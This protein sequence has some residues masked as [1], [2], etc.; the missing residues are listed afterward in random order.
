MLNV[1]QKKGVTFPI[2]DMQD[3]SALEALVSSSIRKSIFK[4]VTLTGG[5]TRAIPFTR[6]SLEIA[7]E[8]KR[9]PVS[10][11]D[12]R[13]LARKPSL[14]EWKE[15]SAV[16]VKVY[17]NKPVT[18]ISDLRSPLEVGMLK[19]TRGRTDL[20]GVSTMYMR[21]APEPFA[22]GQIRLAYHG[23]LNRKHDDLHLEKSEM[24]LKAYKHTGGYVNDLDQY[25][26]Q[27]EISNIVYFLATEYNKS[28]RPR[29][30]ATIQCLQNCVIEETS[31]INE[32]SGDRRFCAEPP[33]PIATGAEFTKYSNNTGYWNDDE[34]DETLLR[35]TLYTYEITGEY[36]MV[37]DL[38]GIRKDGV[39]Y[40]TD[41]VILCNDLLRFGNT[42]L[43]RPFMKKCLE[44]TRA[45][46]AD[47]GWKE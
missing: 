25:L 8:K 37:T 5:A 16:A 4:T 17:R 26:K 13:I 2:V 31:D 14:R 1:F 6:G 15:Q 10:L 7:A 30:C 19:K 42:N 22:E 40:L 43:G 35:F 24:I 47:N 29:H 20:F 32:S 34:I 39:Y 21:R 12:Y 36:L 18:S 27:M 45:Y 28:S 9:S 38:Q 44:S 46:L 41:P 33:L 3:A 23:Q 11:K